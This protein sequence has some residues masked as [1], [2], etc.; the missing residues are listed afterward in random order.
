MDDDHWNTWQTSEE[1]RLQKT[2][3]VSKSKGLNKS[4][5]EKP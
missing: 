5:P 2:E 3:D 1:S 4:L